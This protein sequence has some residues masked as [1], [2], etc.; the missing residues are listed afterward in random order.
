M[1]A[2]TTLFADVSND[3]ALT[4]YDDGLP[5]C[6]DA[7]R[8]L[9]AANPQIAADVQMAI[10]DLLNSGATANDLNTA[11]DLIQ[12]VPVPNNLIPDRG[13]TRLAVGTEREANCKRSM[14]QQRGNT[15]PS[16][17]VTPS[18]QKRATTKKPAAPKAPRAPGAKLI[19][20]ANKPV[21]ALLTAACQAAGGTRLSP[22]GFASY[23][24]FLGGVPLDKDGNA[25]VALIPVKG[26][27]PVKGK[28]V[29]L[30]VKG[31][32]PTVR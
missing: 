19:L 23:T 17:L 5:A 21:R 26:S 28:N 13:E 1:N 4:I 3:R 2:I 22:I 30:I 12:R 6:T 31:G 8:E 10:A 16:A 27:D 14:D 15:K 18:A 29:K 9:A 25:E 11:V 32:V 20:K 24:E 7:A